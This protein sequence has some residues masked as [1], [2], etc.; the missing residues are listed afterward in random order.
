M[1]IIIII[2]SVA[3]Y[4]TW[5]LFSNTNEKNKPIE[6]NRKDADLGDSKKTRTKPLFCSVG[7]AE[8][9]FGQTVREF[10]DDQFLK[11]RKLEKRA[12]HPSLSSLSK[13]NLIKLLQKETQRFWDSV[14]VDAAPTSFKK[15]INL[16]LLIRER[17]R[18]EKRDLGFGFTNTHQTRTFLR[19]PPKERFPK[20]KFFDGK[21]F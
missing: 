16:E 13:E 4:A 20:N 2:T 11:A 18:L 3:G 21:L 17:E 9:F 14:E 8:K 10:C 7:Y 6:G 15:M 19:T 12:S 1:L 5:K